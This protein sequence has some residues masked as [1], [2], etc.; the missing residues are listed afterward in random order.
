MTTSIDTINRLCA[1][2]RTRGALSAQEQAELKAAYEAAGQLRYRAWLGDV[3]LSDWMDSEDD[4]FTEGLRTMASADLNID[5]ADVD[6]D[7][8]VASRGAE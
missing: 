6:I 5:Q 1:L 2:R 8:E 3:A 4:A 7:I